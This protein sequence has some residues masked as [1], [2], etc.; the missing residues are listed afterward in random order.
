M[1]KM[2]SLATVLLLAFAMYHMIANYCS[3]KST[4]GFLD[5]GAS[6]GL[7]HTTSH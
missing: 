3:I 4:L 6:R 7:I 5:C 2:K 1:L